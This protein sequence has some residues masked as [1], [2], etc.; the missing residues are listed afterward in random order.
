MFLIDAINHNVEKK[1]ET[2]FTRL[3]MG[4]ELQAYKIKPPLFLFVLCFLAATKNLFKT[5][6]KKHC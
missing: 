3:F 5:N 2:L 4:S 1:L 6:E